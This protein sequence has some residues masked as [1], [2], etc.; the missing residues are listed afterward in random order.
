MFIHISYHTEAVQNM[1]TQYIA[2]NDNIETGHIVMY[3][4]TVQNSIVCQCY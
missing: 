2:N 1:T 4:M 3:D